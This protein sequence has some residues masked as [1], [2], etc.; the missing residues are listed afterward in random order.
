MK[1]PAKFPGLL[2]ITFGLAAFAVSLV[3][4]AHRQMGTGIAAV[5]FALVAAGVGGA[6]LAREARRMH[7]LHNPMLGAPLVRAGTLGVARTLRWAFG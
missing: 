5:V 6:W 3:C 4:S 1:S 2:S 7:R